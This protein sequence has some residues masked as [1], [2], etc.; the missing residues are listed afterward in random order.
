MNAK[1]I[2]VAIIL[3]GLFSCQ[4][5]E[6]SVN[7]EKIEFK[8]LRTNPNNYFTLVDIQREIIKYEDPKGGIDTLGETKLFYAD[9]LLTDRNWET[10]YMM[11]KHGRTDFSY[12]HSSEFDVMVVLT[13]PDYM[14]FDQMFIIYNRVRKEIPV[15]FVSIKL[16]EVDVMRRV[17][18]ITYNN[19]WTRTGDIPDETE[20]FSF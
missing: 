11:W 8:N 12:A 1:V 4:K 16:T 5:E 9:I 2:L 19:S 6:E 17:L 3:I 10:S 14:V 13:K 18:R 15:N 20:E 7:F